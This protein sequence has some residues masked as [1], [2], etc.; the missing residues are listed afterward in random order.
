MNFG[1][2]LVNGIVLGV[3]Y[4]NKRTYDDKEELVI[5]LFCLV[6]YFQWE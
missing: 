5:Y 4:Y 6:I 1:I 3:S 2:G